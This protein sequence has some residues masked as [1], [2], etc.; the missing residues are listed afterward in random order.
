MEVK[1][2]AAVMKLSSVKKNVLLISIQ[3]IK[4][5]QTRRKT[6]ASFS[7]RFNRISFVKFIIF[8][9]SVCVQTEV[10]VA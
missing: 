9:V 2:S 8:R 6:N 3:N 1:L 4:N 10:G 7:R 5:D